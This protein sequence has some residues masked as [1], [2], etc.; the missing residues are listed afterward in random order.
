MLFLLTSRFT[1][2][3]A[4]KADPVHGKLL[5]AKRCAGCHDLDVDGE[6][7]HLRNVY[8]RKAGKISAFQ[9]SDAMKSAQITWNDTTLDQ[10]LSDPASLVPNTDMDF[11]V[12]KAD[13][14]ADII[15]FLH[16]SSGK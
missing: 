1:T 13:E 4:A 7:P 15:A 11:T 16:A 6:G 10:W 2:R 8:G 12:P 3:A 5:F 14:R 9:Y